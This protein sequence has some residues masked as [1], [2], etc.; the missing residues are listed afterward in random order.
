MGSFFLFQIRKS[1]IECHLIFPETRPF[2]HEPM[3][4]RQMT[5]RYR[6]LGLMAILLIFQISLN[7]GPS[8]HFSYHLK[9]AT[10]GRV[11]LVIPFRV[12]YESFASL[13][14]NVET[15]KTGIQEFYFESV[16][17][18]GYM[19]R[20]S[21]FSGK[22]LVILTA[23]INL[24]QARRFSRKKLDQIADITPYYSRFVKQKKPFL[25][26]VFPNSRNAFH[27]KRSSFGQHTESSCNIKVRFQH[28]PEVLNIDFN[29]YRILREMT[30]AYNHPF[31]PE[32]NLEIIKKNPAM[33]WQSPPLD[34]S[35]SINRIVRLAARV[36]NRLRRFQQEKHFRLTYRLVAMNDKRLIISGTASPDV[37]I[38]GD[39]AISEFSRTVILNP[40]NDD[41]IEDS[42]RL[43]IEDPAGK[44]LEAKISLKKID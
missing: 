34:F 5:G 24:E 42:F 35:A 22:I 30:R 15:S 23:G 18:F 29:I 13:N 2:K 44:G 20:T 40:R 25:F 4:K 8:Y 11:L 10:H 7:A 31:V 27:F 6:V 41:L 14:L 1:P 39:Y 43:K 12:F 9:G 32:N 26:K 37:A 3:N 16:P 19:M 36:M 17:E 38:W 33:T 21:G 28:F